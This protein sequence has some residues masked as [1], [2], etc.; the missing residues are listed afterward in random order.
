MPKI[1]ILADLIG[2]KTLAEE[3]GGIDDIVRFRDEVYR[4]I[5]SS[6]KDFEPNLQVPGG[7]DVRCE[8]VGNDWGSLADKALIATINALKISRE[9]FRY[10]I[11]SVD[12]TSSYEPR[13][14]PFTGMSKHSEGRLYHLAIDSI[15]QSNLRDTLVIEWL[16]ARPRVKID[17]EIPIPKSTTPVHLYLPI[18]PASPGPGGTSNSGKPSEIR[19]S[20]VKGEPSQNRPRSRPK[21]PKVDQQR[22]DNSERP[23][24]P[25]VS[26][27]TDDTSTVETTN[28]VPPYLLQYLLVLKRR[29]EF[30]ELPSTWGGNAPQLSDVFVPP[31]I[32]LLRTSPEYDRI[33][34]EFRRRE[35][36]DDRKFGSRI[37][38]RRRA[39][40]VGDVGAGKGAIMR[41]LAIAYISRLVKDEPRWMQWSKIYELKEIDYLPIFIDLRDVSDAPLRNDA[42]WGELIDLAL[43]PLDTALGG[44]YAAVAYALADR[45][46]AR[47]TSFTS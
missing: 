47:A 15:V 12:E 25:T 41:G 19:N 44:D 11:Y 42:D 9:R 7:D 22:K 10:V 3:P 1:I 45:A 26:V 17:V 39:T 4:S 20:N 40:I 27:R 46:T 5:Q 18:N 24:A 8:L 33:E 21:S 43:K 31:P 38:D 35:P 13:H 28:P 32:T 14:L 6:T 29:L 16:K 30:I 37:A 2:S 36:S 23:P 34:D